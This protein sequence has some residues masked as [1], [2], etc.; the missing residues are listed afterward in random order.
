MQNTK[1]CK[2]ET[3]N[4]KLYNG[5]RCDY[6]KEDD[7][8]RC[9]GHVQSKQ[10]KHTQMKQQPCEEYPNRTKIIL[11]AK[12]KGKNRIK[13]VNTYA[14]PVLTFVFGIV[15]WTPKDLENQI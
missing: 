1:Y 15:K 10:I 6:R 13:S 12:L 2:G 5:G 3:R 14:T 7:V 11:K 4:E 9:L 8:Y